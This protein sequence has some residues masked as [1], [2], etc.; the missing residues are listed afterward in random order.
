MFS[1]L[2]KISQ[3]NKKIYDKLLEYSQTSKG[4]WVLSICSFTEAIFFPIPPDLPLM[5]MCTA[6]PK[7]SFYYAFITLVTSLMGAIA[8]YFIGYF[9]WS[10][11]QGFFYSYVFSKEK[12]DAFQSAFQ[13]NTL[14]TLFLAS[15]TLIPFKV[16]TLASGVFKAPLF[17]FFLGSFV[18]RAGRY[19]I[20]AGLFFFLGDRA[21]KFIDK[22]FDILVLSVSLLIVA[23]VI[24]FISR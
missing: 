9:F 7:R 24:F 23:G 10:E 16:F 13:K 17:L 12:F 22:Y 19:F 11:L 21:K 4:I 2:K 8:G 20:I 14:S 18:G 6:K 1:F 5:A 15:F 3:W